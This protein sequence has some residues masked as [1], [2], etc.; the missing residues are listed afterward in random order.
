MACLPQTVAALTPRSKISAVAVVLIPAH[1]EASVIQATLM[2]LK[3][4]IDEADQ[5][6]VVADNCTDETAEIAH[7]MG[8][9][10]LERVEPERKGKGYALD[11][12]LK[13]IAMNPPNIVIVVDADCLVQADSI[14]WLK[15]QTLNTGNPSQAVYLMTQPPEPGIKAQ[16]SAFAFKVKNWIRPL[17]LARLNL[18]CPLTGTGM[19]FPW[20]AIKSLDIANGEIVE[21]MKMGL[22]LAMA[23]TPPMLCAQARVLGQLPSQSSASISQR[24]RWEHGHLQM[25]KRYVPQ[26]LGQAFIQRRWV[27]AL[28]A[29]DLA[30]P[31]LSL[32]VILWTGIAAIAISFSLLTATWLPT[33]LTA[34]SGSILL[35]AVL[36]AWLGFGRQDLS[37]QTLFLFPFYLLWK[38]PLYLGFLIKPQEQWVRTKRDSAES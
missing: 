31:P 36:M 30:I 10:V 27:L 13:A 9:K 18:P 8:A 15:H 7:S 22:D 37:I 25:L 23:G 28:M 1:D 2:N 38:I 24:T 33:I 17:G 32:L 12:G 16:I 19:A 26:L 3:H 34:T 11:F 6:I 4:E 14:R 5:I 35:L 29:L 21:D 20:N